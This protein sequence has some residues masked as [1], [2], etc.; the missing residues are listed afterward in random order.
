MLLMLSSMHFI[1]LKLFGCNVRKFWQKS[2]SP[3]QTILIITTIINI[4]R[5]GVFVLIACKFIAKYHEG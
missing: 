2:I 3:L 1:T 5:V 4:T